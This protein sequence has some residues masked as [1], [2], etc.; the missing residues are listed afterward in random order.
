M[1]V[2]VMYVEIVNRINTNW[3]MVKSFLWK[4]LN[5]MFAIEKHISS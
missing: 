4:G 5:F 1:C 2:C 3:K